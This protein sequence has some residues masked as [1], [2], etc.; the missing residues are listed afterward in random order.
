MQCSTVFDVIHQFIDFFELRRICNCCNNIF[1][2]L[3]TILN[4]QQQYWAWEIASISAQMFGSTPGPMPGPSICRHTIHKTLLDYICCHRTTSMGTSNSDY[5]QRSLRQRL[6]LSLWAG[7][8][9]RPRRGTTVW[10]SSIHCLISFQVQLRR[11]CNCCNNIFSHPTTTKQ[12]RFWSWEI[13]SINRQ[14]L[15]QFEGKI[16]HCLG[17]T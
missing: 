7:Q 8:L 1:S 2:D 15:Q 12:Q 9:W 14:I 3:T 10:V 17:G 11:I 13:A 5:C 6:T 16:S 4:E